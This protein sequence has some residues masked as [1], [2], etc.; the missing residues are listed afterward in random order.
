MSFILD[1][2]N[3]LRY[4]DGK[5]QFL[6]GL[7]KYDCVLYQLATPWDDLLTLPIQY[8]QRIQIPNTI[9]FVYEKLRSN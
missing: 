1:N 2:E 4:F 9:F 6:L 3:T 5:I 8:G 7:G